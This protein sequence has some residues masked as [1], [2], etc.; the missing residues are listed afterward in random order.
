MVSWMVGWMVGKTISLMVSWIVGWIVG[1]VG[2]LGD[3]TVGCHELSGGYN[4]VRNSR[5]VVGGPP[6]R[7]LGVLH[8]K[9]HS[10]RRAK[11]ETWQE[12]Q[13]QSPSS[14]LRGLGV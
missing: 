3:S 8:L 14:S 12:E 1:I 4:H 9:Q 13:S 2:W 10:V 11:F 5:L 7:G 6:L